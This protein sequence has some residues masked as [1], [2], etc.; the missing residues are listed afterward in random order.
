MSKL[1][2]P[3]WYMLAFGSAFFVSS[4]L[5]QAF[6]SNPVTDATHAADYFNHPAVPKRRLSTPLHKAALENDRE[7]ILMLHATGEDVNVG[8]WSGA[9]PLHYAAEAGSTEATETLLGLNANVNATTVNAFTPMHRAAQHDKKAIIRLL[10]QN[11][12]DLDSRTDY[13]STPLHCATSKSHIDAMEEL[14]FLGA[15]IDAGDDEDNTPLHVAVLNNHPAAVR[16]LHEA[17]ASLNAKDNKDNVPLFY[18]HGEI[19]SYLREA[20]Q[21]PYE[22]KRN[23]P[24]SLLILSTQTIRREI[25]LGN[26]QEE[27]LLRMLPTDL[28]KRFK[29]NFSI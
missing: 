9:T 19:L 22:I 1:L 29:T 25:T 26:I 15:L 20:Q 14:I 13:R 11:E 28:T 16:L 10:Y 27:T 12:A 7:K 23:F 5:Y 6:A 4:S 18:A 2:K 21:K 3:V 8:D 17:G 24:P